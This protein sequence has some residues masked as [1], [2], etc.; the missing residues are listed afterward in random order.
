MADHVLTNLPNVSNGG[1]GVETSALLTGFPNHLYI[2]EKIF[3]REHVGIKRSE[4]LDPLECI[5]CDDGR[6]TDGLYRTDTVTL[7][8]DEDDASSIRTRSLGRVF[9]AAHALDSEVA[10]SNDN[11]YDS[12]LIAKQA[13]ERHARL[14]PSWNGWVETV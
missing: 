3:A 13:A 4:K 11:G 8:G 7:C 12:A 2:A 9:F 5:P 1:N 10:N 14:S 6:R